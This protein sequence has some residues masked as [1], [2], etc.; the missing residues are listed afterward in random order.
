[1][2]KENRMPIGCD[3]RSGDFSVVEGEKDPRGRFE[4][5][6]CCSEMGCCNGWAM[7]SLDRSQVEQ[8][9]RVMG[10]WLEGLADGDAG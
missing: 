1:M 9:H 8:I 3:L 7:K 4:V 10:K 6:V 2:G 5:H